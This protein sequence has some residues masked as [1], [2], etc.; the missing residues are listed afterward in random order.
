MF[1]KVL[2]VHPQRIRV[3]PVLR[4]IPVNLR[5]NPD[6]KEFVTEQALRN[7][8]ERAGRNAP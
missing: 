2:Y 3:I 4:M 1:T 7:V 5:A 6:Y 8:F